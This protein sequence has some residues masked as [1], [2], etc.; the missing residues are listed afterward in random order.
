MHEPVPVIDVPAV[1]RTGL[2]QAEFARRFGFPLDTL[3]NWKHRIRTPQD[4]A[5][6]LSR[7]ID[8]KPE[9]R[10]GRSAWLL[11]RSQLEG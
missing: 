8:A 10:C 2:I 1:R 5:R 6:A 3:R 7:V 9:R 11:E 4:P